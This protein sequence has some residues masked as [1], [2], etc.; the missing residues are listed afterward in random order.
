MI[1]L[2][3]VMIAKPNNHDAMMLLLPLL[4]PVVLKDVFVWQLTR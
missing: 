1:M 4:L 3:A 2:I